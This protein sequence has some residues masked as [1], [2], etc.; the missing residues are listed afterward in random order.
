MSETPPSAATYSAA[1]GVATITL[2][3]PEKLNAFNAAMFA[4]IREGLDKAESD[5]SVRVVVF[6]GAGRAFSSGQDLTEKL[7]IGADGKL[8]LGPPLARDY[9]PLALRLIDYPKITVAALNG[10]AVGAAANLAL[11]CD[12]AVATRSAYIQQAFARIGLAPDAGGTW[13]LPRIVGMKRALALALTGDRLTVEEA[14]NMGLIYRVFDDATFAADLAGFVGQFS[15]GPAVAYHVI[16]QAFA[17]SLDSDFATQLQLESDLQQK[18]G[19]T[20]D[21]MEAVMAFAMKRT[22]SF[23]GK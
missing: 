12:I 16:K 13:L 18:L 9:N 23:K 14:Q 2:N 7:P 8:D 6:T 22:P 5:E 10:P 15:A 11:S 4:G 3:R 20:D 1:N 19:K 21:F 17:K